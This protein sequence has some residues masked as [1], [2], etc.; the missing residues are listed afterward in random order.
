MMKKL[1][2]CSKVDLEINNHT[3]LVQTVQINS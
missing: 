1:Q 2:K 3:V